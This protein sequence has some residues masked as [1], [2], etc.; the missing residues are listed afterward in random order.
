MSLESR[1]VTGWTLSPFCNKSIKEA[2]YLIVKSREKT[3]ISCS[4]IAEKDKQTSDSDF[5]IKT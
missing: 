2:K 5:I 3:T 1:G 4:Y